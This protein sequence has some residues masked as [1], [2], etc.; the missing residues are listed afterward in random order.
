MSLIVNAPWKNITSFASVYWLRLI[1]FEG[2]QGCL[3]RYKAMIG[4][5]HR[6]EGTCHTR[7]AM[8]ILTA[9]FVW[10]RCFEPKA[11]SASSELYIMFKSFLIRDYKVSPHRRHLIASSVLMTII[12]GTWLQLMLR[13]AV[14]TRTAS[15]RSL[16]ILQ[17][18]TPSLRDISA[19]RNLFH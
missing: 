2:Y 18:G 4:N 9:T 5:C 14:E 3:F 19:L 10:K 7:G 6:S 16:E 11:T 15:L 17:Q 13:V 8:I 12:I 1:G